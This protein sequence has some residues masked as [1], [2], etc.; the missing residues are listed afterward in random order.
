MHKNFYH[1]CCLGKCGL[2]QVQPQTH[3]HSCCPFVVVF[4]LVAFFFS[5]LRFFFKELCSLFSFKTH[6]WLLCGDCITP[7]IFTFFSC[8]PSW[9]AF[10]NLSLPVL[11]DA[12]TGR[13]PTSSLSSQHLPSPTSNFH[14]LWRSLEE[15]PFPNKLDSHDQ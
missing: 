9:P 14:K 11:C 2:L 1:R 12:S 3:T 4:F 7:T 5:N 6:K 13:H 10:Q 8:A 15:P